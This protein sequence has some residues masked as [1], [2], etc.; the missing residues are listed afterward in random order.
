VG[1]LMIQGTTRLLPLLV[2]GVLGTAANAYSFQAWT[3]ALPLFTVA[4]S[5][6]S[7]LTVESLTHP[8]EAATYARRMLL[9]MGRLL[10]PASLLIAVAAPYVLELF[11]PGY[12]DQATVLL[13]LLGLSAI[14]ITLNV[15]YYALCR[16]GGTVMPILILQTIVA[17]VTLAISLILLPVIG[18]TGTG[19]GWLIGQSLAAFFVLARE[20]RVDS[21]RGLHWRARHLDRVR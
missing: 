11:G 20:F 5:M 7:S 3:V 17:A 2:I 14:P 10:V 21:A 18:I 8:G 19:V 12:A 15:W 6:M 13:R 4:G 9:N 1:N 16:I